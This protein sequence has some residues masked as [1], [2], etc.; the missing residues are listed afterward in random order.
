MSQKLTLE[1]TD[2]IHHGSQFKKIF[3]HGS[4]YFVASI[5]TKA[6][7]LLLL[8]AYTRY[9]SLE[10]YGIQNSLNTVTLLIPIFISLYL[11]SSF[12]RYYFL[13]KTVSAQRVKVL[14]S[15]HFWFICMWGSGVVLV[16]LLISPYTLEPLLNIP[17]LPYI[18][19]TIAPAL[20]G[21]LGILGSV[22]FR[23]NLKA[24]EISIL[25]YVVFLSSTATILILLIPFNMGIQAKF[26][27]AAVGVLINFIYFFDISV[28]HSLLG[29]HFD[30]QM[31]KRSLSYS[32]PLIPNIAGGWISG[33][34]DR[35]ILAYYGAIA[36]VG[37]YFRLCSNSTYT[38]YYK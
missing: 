35:L 11:D 29:F 18:P 5:L 6:T 38:I 32:I 34:S 21:Q 25:N 22:L 31:L 37:L 14:Y 33:L 2:A 19:L 16:A 20:F 15:T 7:G 9:L 8:P 17:F 12:G 27:G 28:K 13:E 30:W 3:K 4:W 24:K 36:Q 1:N 26:Y 23:A 10:D